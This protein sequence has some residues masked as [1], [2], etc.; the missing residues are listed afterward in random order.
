VDGLGGATLTNRG[1]ENLIR[2]WLGEDG[3]G[4]L[5]KRIKKGA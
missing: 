5:L 2:Y 4:P 3:F 1:V